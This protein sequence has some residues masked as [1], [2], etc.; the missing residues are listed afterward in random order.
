MSQGPKIPGLRIAAATRTYPGET[1]CGDMVA[2]WRE[3]ED[4]LA[5]IVDGLGHGPDAHHAARSLLALVKGQAGVAPT[6]R[7]AAADG[8]M[9][10]TRGAAAAFLRIEPAAQTITVAAVGN[11]QGALFAARTLRFDGMP[12]IVGAG[13]RPLKP[14][15]VRF[16]PA[17]ILVLWS[18]GLLPVDLEADAR[19]VREDP[20]RL[21]A[22][23]MT[24]YGRQS[25]D[26]A[27][28]CVAFQA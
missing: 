13:L 5:C 10:H 20:E 27:V 28:L 12:G 22:H 25:D 3:G 26:C 2:W 8:V 17:D 7:L 16:A 14:L 19:N 9:R 4:A 6:Q 15:T 23:L 24:R 21:A 18:D 1:A 11:I